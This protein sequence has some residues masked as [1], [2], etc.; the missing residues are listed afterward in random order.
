MLTAQRDLSYRHRGGGRGDRR[1]AAAV[2]FS[3]TATLFFLLVLQPLNLHVSRSSV[4]LPT[5][6]R[7]KRPA[8][9]SFL[10]PRR[11]KR[12]IWPIRYW[13]ESA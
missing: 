9:S 8:M 13:P 6:R 3:M 4:I 11:K 1:A 5:M 7:T 12:R 2:E 10:V